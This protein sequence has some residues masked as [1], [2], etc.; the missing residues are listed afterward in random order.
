MNIHE[1][2]KRLLADGIRVYKHQES[3]PVAYNIF[4]DNDNVYSQFDK[5]CKY[6]RN[7]LHGVYYFYEIKN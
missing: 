7:V 4:I 1:Y 6:S 5:N 3:Y 2:I